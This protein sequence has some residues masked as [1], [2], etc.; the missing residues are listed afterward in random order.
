MSPAQLSDNKN[1]PIF[2]LEKALRL[3]L[4]RKGLEVLLDADPHFI[5]KAFD[6]MN[7]DELSKVKEIL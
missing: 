4:G 7:K 6:T 2:P 5:Q 3:S 1:K